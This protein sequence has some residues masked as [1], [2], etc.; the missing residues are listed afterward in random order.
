[1]AKSS[2]VE[3]PRPKQC[4][5][6]IDPREGVCN[7]RLKISDSKDGSYKS[8]KSPNQDT[9]AWIL[10]AGSSSLCQTPPK[11]IAI[12]R[13]WFEE[14]NLTQREKVFFLTKPIK[15]VVYQKQLEAKTAAQP[16]RVW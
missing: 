11:T 4:F 3:L 1:M 5:D 16:P 13:T 12:L 2:E 8:I 6:R 14:K 10:V 7:K 9:V 15:S